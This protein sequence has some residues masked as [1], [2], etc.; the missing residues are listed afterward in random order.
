MQ[1]HDLQLDIQL[2]HKFYVATNAITRLYRPILKELELTYPQYLVMIVLWEQYR[3]NETISLKISEISKV[4]KMDLGA[5]SLILNKLTSKNYVSISVDNLDHRIKNVSLT[6][7][8]LKLYKQAQLVPTKIGEHFSHMDQ[9]DF[10]AVT[11]Q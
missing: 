2:C 5:L 6:S 7:H 3:N 8:G 1:K 4:S 10:A 9:N 11:L